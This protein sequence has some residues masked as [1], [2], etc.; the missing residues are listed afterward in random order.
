[1][2]EHHMYTKEQKEQLEKVMEVFQDYLKESPYAEVVWS[3]KIGYIFLNVDMK[4]QDVD[5][6]IPLDCAE[7]L[8]SRLCYEVAQDVLIMTGN[9]HAV[10]EADPLETAEIW[11]RLDPYLER[12]P[13]YRYLTEKMFKTK[14]S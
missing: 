13:E 9:D 8:F 11:R 14:E 12:L 5:L 10:R 7:T 3:E 2:E 6:M 1:M 4:Y